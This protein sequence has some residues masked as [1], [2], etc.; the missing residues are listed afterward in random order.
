M[1]E[2]QLPSDAGDD[3]PGLPERNEDQRPDCGGDDV[4]VDER[5]E[6]QGSDDGDGQEIPGERARRRASPYRGGR[7]GRPS[8]RQGRFHRYSDR[9]PKHP[10]GLNAMKSSSS[11]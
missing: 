1:A 5:N 6:R 3:V 10:V 4:V 11:T 8:P 2:R 7:G 9:T